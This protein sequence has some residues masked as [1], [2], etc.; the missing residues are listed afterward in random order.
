LVTCALEGKFAIR[1]GEKLLL[2]ESADVEARFTGQTVHVRIERIDVAKGPVASA[3]VRAPASP[4]SLGL[5][6]RLRLDA[7]PLRAARDIRVAG[8]LVIIPRGTALILSSGEDA[9]LGVK[10]RYGD[11]GVA[12]AASCDDV[13]L[14]E[15]AVS[16]PGPRRASPMHAVAKRVTLLVAPE[17]PTVL[18]LEPRREQPTFDVIES[19]GSFRRVR[20]D[21]GV[22]IDGWVRAADLAPGEGPDCDDCHGGIMDVDDVC[23]PPR[24]CPDEKGGP[25]H[26]RRKVAVRDRPSPEGRPLGWLDEDGEVRIVGRKGTYARI[27]AVKGEIAPPTGGFWI[28]AASLDPRGK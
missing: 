8:D 28:D 25:F 1:A 4:P 5:Q 13:E 24:G 3:I 21:D 18:E 23:P 6:G 10:P 11:F 7:V 19:R 26:A 17:G 2:G 20:Y 27:E 14:G 9:A 16:G 22:R 15:P 12:A